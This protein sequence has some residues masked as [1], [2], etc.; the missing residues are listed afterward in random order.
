[1]KKKIDELER[2]IKAKEKELEKLVKDV[3]EIK[4]E[5]FMLAVRIES[6]EMRKEDR[7][8]AVQK[9]KEKEMK[10]LDV[11]TKIEEEK[12][13][14]RWLKKSKEDLEEEE[15]VVDEYL[16]K[17]YEEEKERK[18]EKRKGDTDEEDESREPKR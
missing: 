14:I 17:Y 18:R 4:D 2:K 6:G 1:M 15:T 9:Q 13:E 11:E 8:N 12:E 7:E 10:K 16:Q 3:G 5:L